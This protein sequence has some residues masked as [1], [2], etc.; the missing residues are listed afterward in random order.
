MWD[1]CICGNPVSNL[2]FVTEH[3]VLATVTK[4]FARRQ[5]NYPLTWQAGDPLVDP[6]VQAMV[7]DFTSV[8]DCIGFIKELVPVCNLVEP[9]FWSKIYYRPEL[10]TGRV[11]AVCTERAGS[12]IGKRLFIVNLAVDIDVRFWTPIPQFRNNGPWATCE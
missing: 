7:L 9:R 4:I 3:G 12:S 10:K 5:G 2:T 6:T 8:E 11:F 1:S